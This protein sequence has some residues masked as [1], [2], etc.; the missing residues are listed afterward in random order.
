MDNLNDSAPVIVAV[1]ML[2]V[3]MY[4]HLCYPKS[5]DLAE[6]HRRLGAGEGYS[7]RYHTAVERAVTDC[8]GA[9]LSASELLTVFPKE[10]SN[11]DPYT[12][13]PTP[14]GNAFATKHC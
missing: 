13:L 11:D 9:G 2:I 6:A 5:V 10:Y 8:V 14:K 3:A 7:H 4:L 12:P 1:T